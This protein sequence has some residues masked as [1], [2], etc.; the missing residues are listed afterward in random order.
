MTPSGRIAPRAED[1]FALIEV[2]VSALILAI[3]AAGVMALLQ[4]TTHSAAAERQHAEAYA[5][6]Q[7][8]QAR[9]RSMRLSALNNLNEPESVTVGGDQFTVVSQGVFVNNGN[10]QPSTCKS[11]ETSA[12]YV[13]LTSTVSWS[14]SRE[15]VVLQSI[16]S[17]SNGSLDPSH[18]T[19]IVTTQSQSGEPVSGVGLSGSGAGTFTGTTDSTGCA[20]FTDLPSGSYTVTPS[21]TGL[22]DKNG[23]A[24][25]AESTSVVAGGSATLPL[26][27]DH[28]AKIPV[29]FKYRIG[30]TGTYAAATGDSV[31]VYNSIMVPA[32]KAYWTS[33]KERQHEFLVAPVFPYSSPV[34][35]YAGFCEKNNPGTGPGQA[36][37]TLNAGTTYSPTV[38]LREP[39][40]E[41]TVKN[42]GAAINGA[43]VTITDKECK[44]SE[45]HSVKR[46]YSTEASGHQSNPSTGASELGLPYGNYEVCGSSTISG[47][48]RHITKSITVHNLESATTLTLDLSSGYSSGACP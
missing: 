36:N 11:G 23:N 13:R 32:G 16:V 3:V 24:P 10:G 4:A 34:T 2:L 43:R 19:L 8:D 6:A 21:G 31:F 12:D 35:L 15:P 1:G 30:N 22:V 27:Y 42:G 7:E 9:M 44:D 18:G 20:Y 14:G 17:P 33:G 39:E 26:V 45:S 25:K 46:V 38:E 47:Y 40:F 28:E 48:A 37:I 5:L 41:L 29:S